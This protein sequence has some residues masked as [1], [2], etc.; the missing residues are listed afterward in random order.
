[1]QEPIPHPTES[2]A[3]FRPADE[4][5][6]PNAAP[7]QASGEAMAEGGA[8]GGNGQQPS[9][10]SRR[11]RR[12]RKKPATGV[13]PTHQT[14]PR[15]SVSV[16]REES[17]DGFVHGITPNAPS[18]PMWDFGSDRAAAVEAKTSEPIGEA[19]Y[20]REAMSVTESRSG[21]SEGTT[22]PGRERRT[23][24]I[25]SASGMAE[26]LPQNVPEPAPATEEPAQP[27]RRGWWQRAFKS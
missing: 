27:P 17:G 10:S 11:R 18:E 7:A 4:Q 23:E 5:G 1:M 16:Q 2:D 19:Y 14:E 13:Q 22:E 15:E 12:R 20:R 24:H 6:D 21:E 26:S 3:V 9:G 25:A 8:P